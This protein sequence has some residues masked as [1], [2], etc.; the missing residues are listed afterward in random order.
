MPETLMQLVLK[1]SRRCEPVPIFPFSR[2]FDTICCKN[3]MM[4]ISIYHHKN[5][6]FANIRFVCVLR[7]TF[8][9]RVSITLQPLMKVHSDILLHF[10]ACV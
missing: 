8:Q 2:N 4:V 1:H 3:T 6:P 5:Y 10:S 9:R 7:M